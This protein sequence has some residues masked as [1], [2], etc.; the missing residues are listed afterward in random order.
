VGHTGE[1]ETDI[2]A[3]RKGFVT[4]TPLDFDL[5]KRSFVA[6]M[7]HWQFD[8]VNPTGARSNP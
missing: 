8:L 4:L 5:T 1:H 7:E 2:S 3:L 6:E